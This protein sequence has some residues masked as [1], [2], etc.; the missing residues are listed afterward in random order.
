[1]NNGMYKGFDRNILNEARLGIGLDA[2]RFNRLIELASIGF[3]AFYNSKEG[4][5]LTS[6]QCSKF[7]KIFDLGAEVVLDRETNSDHLYAINYQTKTIRIFLT[8]VRK[9]ADGL[10]YMSV[11]KGFEPLFI[12]EVA[13]L[14]AVAKLKA[15]DDKARWV[16]YYTDFL[17]YAKE[18][19]YHIC[20]D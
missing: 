11:D 6:E 4:F 12:V 7:A 8:A 18:K 14:A 10:D 2:A 1:M 13:I 5:A 15:S 19:N 3:D 20:Q 17:L 9:K 16:V